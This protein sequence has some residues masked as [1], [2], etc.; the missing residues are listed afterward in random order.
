MK[1]GHREW[2]PPIE[3]SRDDRARRFAGARA[4]DQL[5]MHQRQ[6]E[7][8]LIVERASLALSMLTEHAHELTTEQ[9]RELHAAIDA[10]VDRLMSLE[11]FERVED[12]RELF[13]GDVLTLGD[14]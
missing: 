7:L 4:P 1:S 9:R 2:T 6:I 11:G 12:L 8:G 3:P 10:M 13:D 14:S 5:T